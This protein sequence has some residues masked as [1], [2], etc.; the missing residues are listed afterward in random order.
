MKHIMGNSAAKPTETNALF[1]PMLCHDIKSST[2]MITG[3]TG[4]MAANSDSMDA[5]D[6]TYIRECVQMI[7][8][9]SKNLMPL[10]DDL[11]AIEKYPPDKV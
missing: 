6:D 1:L 5:L 2:D 3:F 11:S 10:I 9:A 8:G 7:L 4:S